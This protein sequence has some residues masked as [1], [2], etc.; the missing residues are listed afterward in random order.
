M[1]KDHLLQLQQTALFRG[2]DA[3]NIAGMLDCLQAQ[4]RAYKKGEAVFRQGEQLSQI[5][6]RKAAHPERRLLG[7][8]H[9]H[10]RPRARRSL[11]RSLRCARQRTNAGRCRL[12]QRQRCRSLSGAAHAHRLHQRLPLPQPRRAKSVLCPR[13]Q[14]SH[15]HA[16]AQPTR[17]PY[18]SCQAHQL[19][20]RR[21]RAR[22]VRKLHHPLQSPAARRLSLR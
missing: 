22:R 14:K 6:R 15:P 21:K 16:K 10:R 7:Q 4:T 5:A 19:S 9:H 8:P 17:H 3:D 2:V 20:H 11:R 1:K 12:R 13:R 18:H